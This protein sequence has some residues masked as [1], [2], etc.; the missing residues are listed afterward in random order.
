MA[1]NLITPPHLAS[2][3]FTFPIAGEENDFILPPSEALETYDGPGWTWTPGLFNIIWM[4]MDL[5]STLTGWVRAK[6]SG[7]LEAQL[8]AQLRLAG[9]PLAFFQAITAAL[10]WL[11]EL[12]YIIYESM[13]DALDPVTGIF[14]APA[15]VLGIG[16]CVVQ[17]IYE[18]ICVGRAIELL[19]HTH[20]R[21]LKE[22][23]TLLTSNPLEQSS[24]IEAWL[25]ANPEDSLPEEAKVLHRQLT[26][27]VKEKHG[28]LA[29][30]DL[31]ATLKDQMLLDGLYFD[32]EYLSLTV[33]EKTRMANLVQRNFPNL[34]I[35]EQR[36]EYVN[37]AANLTRAKRAN[38]DRRVKPWCGLKVANE[39]KPLMNALKDPTLTPLARREAREQAENFLQA[40]DTQGKKRLAI[41]IVGLIA[42]AFS[43]AGFLCT[44]LACPALI[45]FLLL[46]A[47]GVLSTL[48]YI[49]GRAA[50]DEEGFTWGKAARA[51]MPPLAWVY[52]RITACGQTEEPVA[53][54]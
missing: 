20:T 17:G 24:N 22:L 43:A 53:A 34:E 9:M 33:E 8:D 49:Y 18:S 31:L 10:T 36:Q 54:S 15:L 50:L 21:S 6:A 2:V 4:P 11:L 30:H 37:M 39:L 35:K 14:G 25:A 51:A 3:P 46:T 26:I 48:S 27:S 38:L 13:A 32:A 19:S 42:L 12:G 40:L 7:D 44:L 28:L 23:N 16:F 52:D 29:N 45:P 5:V 47:G 1:A 41:H